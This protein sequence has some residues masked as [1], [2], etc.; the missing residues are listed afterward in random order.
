MI[1]TRLLFLK[2]RWSRM[3][4][5]APWVPVTV[6]IMSN[7]RLMPIPSRIQGHF[8]TL[9][10]AAEDKSADS[11]TSSNGDETAAEIA[12]TEAQTKGTSAVPEDLDYY[13]GLVGRQ[14]DIEGGLGKDEVDVKKNYPIN[15]P[16][17]LLLLLATVACIAFIGSIFEVTGPNPE[18][19]RLSRRCK[20]PSGDITYIYIV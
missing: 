2:G 15:L 10:K 13:S 8:I 17:Y 20:L 7:H 9:R 4:C 12:V 1:P 5:F 18:V 19:R 3:I 16:S 6:L 11:I 14:P